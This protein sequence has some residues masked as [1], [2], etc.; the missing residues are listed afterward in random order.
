MVGQVDGVNANFKADEHAIDTDAV[1]N[2]FNDELSGL[3]D[4]MNEFLDGG[5]LSD[6]ATLV[7]YQE[8]QNE[9][10]MILSFQTNF[11]KSL[12]DSQSQSINNMK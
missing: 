8:L 10:L 7:K 3:K 6:P 4:K 2:K 12:K 9:Y 5:N 11:I 1:L